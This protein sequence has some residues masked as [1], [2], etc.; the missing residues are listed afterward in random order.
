MVSCL[1]CGLQCESQQ[2][3]LY[4]PG[5]RCIM[6]LLAASTHAGIQARCRVAC[7]STTADSAIL[8][9]DAWR[10]A[11]DSSI[12]PMGQP[13]ARQ[14][15]A[16]SNTMASGT[17][18][19]SQ[20]QQRHSRPH[21]LSATA[22][23]MTDQVCGRFSP[24]PRNQ[25]AFNSG[26]VSYQARRFSSTAV[27]ASPT[28]AAGSSQQALGS[29]A[30]MSH[31]MCDSGQARGISVSGTAPR[32]TAHSAKRLSECSGLGTSTGGAVNTPHTSVVRRATWHCSF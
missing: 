20:A 25:G 6:R 3:M 7:I 1:E 5:C 9:E 13:P 17:H 4:R 12:R 23:S 22:S 18:T 11:S 24:V 15:A 16:A 30:H 31:G 21:R 27:P 26:R 29:P 14:E 19:P 10:H 8:F 28:Q 2:C 32:M